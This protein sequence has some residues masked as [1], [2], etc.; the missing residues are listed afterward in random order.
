MIRKRIL[1]NSNPIG[2]R[3]YFLTL[4]QK[5]IIRAISRTFEL[6]IGE[7][8]KDCFS[9]LISEFFSL[10]IVALRNDILLCNSQL[11][12]LIITLHFANRV[13]PLHIGKWFQ[14][15][16]CWTFS[17][18]FYVRKKFLSFLEIMV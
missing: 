15:S 1:R 5:L 16:L 12:T 13:F 18:D 6:V 11:A 17:Q 8:P 4:F 7:C 2:Q 9:S 10:F 14:D 3:Q